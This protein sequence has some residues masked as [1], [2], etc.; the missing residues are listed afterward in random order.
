MDKTLKGEFVLNTTP[1]TSK[2]SSP[3]KKEATLHTTHK[4]SPHFYSSYVINPK[5]ISFIDQE[6]DEEILLFIRRHFITNVPWLVGSF[7]LAILPVTLFPYLIAFSPFPAL[8]GQTL[9]LMIFFYYLIIFG[10]VLLKFTLWYFHVGIITNK[11]VVD[12]DIHGILYKDISEARNEY[13]Q[14][15]SYSQIGAV[16]SLFN[17]GD[18]FVQTAGSMQNIEFDRAPR[19]ATIARIIGDLL[20]GK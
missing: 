18:V 2:E 20:G 9:F 12:I 15:V 4:N 5:N 17:Y 13:I 6:A 19:P 1:K 7:L 8:N 11:R 10:Y 16:R 14:D 3:E